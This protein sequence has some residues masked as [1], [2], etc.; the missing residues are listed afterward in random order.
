MR[1]VGVRMRMRMKMKMRKRMVMMKVMWMKMNEI[2]V[3]K[4]SQRA[5]NAQYPDIC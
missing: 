5:W 3:E 4:S 2:R 1:L